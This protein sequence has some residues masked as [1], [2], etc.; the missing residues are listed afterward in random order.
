MNLPQFLN[1]TLSCAILVWTPLLLVQAE[2]YFHPQSTTTHWLFRLASLIGIVSLFIP[3]G[4][5]LGIL[6]GVPWFLV[7]WVV[8]ALG[9]R[10]L[11]RWGLFGTSQSIIGWC[12]ILLAGGGCWYFAARLNQ[13]LLGFF[14][15][16]KTLTAIHFHFAGFAIPLSYALFTA[17]LEQRQVAR[18]GMMRNALMVYLF[19]FVL[20]AAGISGFVHFDKVGAILMAGASFVVIAVSLIERRHLAQGKLSEALLALSAVAGVSALTLG[21]LYPFRAGPFTDFQTMA[22][23]HGI[24]NA[25]LWT[26]SVVFTVV[27]NRLQ[28]R[29]HRDAIPF[30]HLEAAKFVGADFFKAMQAPGEIHGL[31]DAFSAF[32]RSDFDPNLVDPRVQDFYTQTDRYQLNVSAE[33]SPLFRQLWSKIVGPYFARVEQLNLPTADKQIVGRLDLLNSD[34]DGRQNP[35]G[36]TR[37]DLSTGKAVYVAAYAMHANAEAQYMNI[38]FP[39]PGGN[40]T[41]ILLPLNSREHQNGLLLTTLREARSFG[42]QGVFWAVSGVGVRLPLNETIEVYFDSALKA[43]HRMWFLGW[44]YLT[45]N[46][47]IAPK[48]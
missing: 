27:L 11:L 32:G 45:L 2:R 19:G 8:G 48:S 33:A 6:A 13:P 36:W 12:F 5:A 14:E 47:Q 22:S 28:S 7:C 15:P 37:T 18:A 34:L 42:D 40:M 21:V 20:V 17:R 29:D 43:R 39:L 35:R 23:T 25:F 30:S 16:W 26:P 3:A 44:P 4:T 10:R 31:I 9:L 46:Y 41:S 1:L 38:A 24:M